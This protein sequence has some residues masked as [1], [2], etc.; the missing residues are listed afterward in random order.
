MGV[1]DERLVSLSFVP[2]LC[3]QNEQKIT[4]ALRHSFIRLFRLECKTWR[5]CHWMPCRFIHVITAADWRKGYSKSR[6]IHVSVVGIKIIFEQHLCVSHQKDLLCTPKKKRYLKKCTHDVGS[7]MS[8]LLCWNLMG[9][10]LGHVPALS[11]NTCGVFTF[12][13]QASM[14]QGWPLSFI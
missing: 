2:S 3:A 13:W 7:G 14:L 12:L 11:P 10:K 8:H 6:C 1:T 5:L 4:L 9:F